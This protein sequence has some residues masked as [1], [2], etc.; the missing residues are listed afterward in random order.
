MRKLRRQALALP[1]QQGPEGIG[2]PCGRFWVPEERA[3]PLV[4]FRADDVSNLQAWIMCFGIV[5][6]ERV[7]E[8]SLS[9]PMAAYHVARAA[10][11]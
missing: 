4:E 7:L 8:Q 9:E 6:R 5:D 11:P 3:N 1:L 2:L 10:A